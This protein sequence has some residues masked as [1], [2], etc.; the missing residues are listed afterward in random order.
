MKIQ[1][2]A[3]IFL[4]FA[5][6][7]FS[8]VASGQDV[9]MNHQTGVV[10]KVVEISF[11]S[12]K[13]YGDPFNEV[14]VDLNVTAPDGKQA[15]VPAFWTGKQSWRVRYS[16]PLKG[17]H[18]WK[19]EC[20]DATNAKLHGVEGTIDL[21]PY[22]GDQ[23]FYKHG[24]V[25][26]APDKR[27]LMYAD[28]TPFFWLGDTWWMGL[29]N[30]LSYPDDFQKL[31]A[32]RKAK[33]FNVI[34]LVA[35]LYPDMHPFDPRGANEAGFP[36]EEKY[37]RIRP[38][39]FDA[40]DQ[41]IDY[42][43]DQGLMP[44]IVGAWGYF[45]PWMG[46][47]KLEQHWRY[48]IAR[49]GAMP[50]VW[51][52]AGEA[53]LNWYLDKP[54][55]VDARAQVTEWTKVMKYIRATDPFHRLL[56]IHPTGIGRLSARHATDDVGLLDI[57]MLQTPHGERDAV[58]ATI[59]TV[60]ESVA[61][62][63]VMPVINGEASYEML[64]DRIG[65]RW[66]RQMFWICMT[67]GAAGHT[68]G[69][70]GIW[71]VNRKGKPHGGSPHHPP[72]STGYGVIAWDDAMNLGGSTHVALGKKLF[73]QYDWQKWQP[74]KGW[75][76]YATKTDKTPTYGPFVIG[77]EKTRLIYVP[78]LQAIR[79]AKLDAGAEYAAKM[80]NPVTGEEKSAGD[81]KVDGGACTV[82]PPEQKDAE[83]WVVVIERK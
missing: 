74:Q 59:R 4:A 44:C 45:M 61:D 55:P 83:D 64:M 76:E 46:E 13:S 51:C 60:A 33:G 47:K 19:I 41:R 82:T 78:E 7:I 50:V 31:A 68:Y 5:S 23:P 27:H 24:F 15:R 73:E 9:S 65:T 20:S 66:T 38:E 57:D 81:V 3:R 21:S 42:L 72:G 32:D 16:S 29:C 52:A 1:V 58:D 56:T 22:V 75:A 26:V 63:P 36:W 79:V 49:Y 37:A 17:T 80:F 43:V 6:L 10:N 25:Q 18:R 48:L 30:R 39:Y 69:A 11:E 8:A 34:Q 2:T 53:N 12:A 70:N 77:D 28:G 35:G 14:Q 71:Q 40:A 67:E 54:F 62:K